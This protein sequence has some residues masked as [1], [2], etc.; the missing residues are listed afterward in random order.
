MNNQFDPNYQSIKSN[1]LEVL[2]TGV[3]LTKA[4]EQLHL[5]RQTVT[6]WGK[7]AGLTFTVSDKKPINS[8]VFNKVDTEE[9]AYWLGF[10]YAD[11]YV[12]DDNHIEIGLK[13]SDEEHLN[14][15]V[16]FLSFGGKIYKDSYRVRLCFKDMQIGNDLKHLGCIPRKSLVLQFPTEKQVPTYLLNHFIRGYYDGDGCILDPAKYAFGMSLIGTK[17]FLNGVLNHLFLNSPNIIKNS[18][19]SESVFQIQLHGKKSRL[20]LKEIYTDS[21][22]YLKRKHDRYLQHIIRYSKRRN[23]L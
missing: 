20:F 9:K 18:K 12:S 19:S 1:A 5:D 4:A 11:G 22:V 6:K 17:N 16:S 21:T 10:F 14:K 13:L 2:R 15:L 3:S 7:E 8:I 23:Y